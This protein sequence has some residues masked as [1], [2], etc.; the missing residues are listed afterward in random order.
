[1]Q[2]I[3]IFW[4]RQLFC[5][6][7]AHLKIP[8]NRFHILY[9]NV[10]AMLTGPALNSW[11]ALFPVIRL[12]PA[13]SNAWALKFS[14]TEWQRLSVINYIYNK[15]SQPTVS[16]KCASPSN[17]IIFCAIWLFVFL[18]PHILTQACGHLS[19]VALPRESLASFYFISILAS[20]LTFLYFVLPYCF[21]WFCFSVWV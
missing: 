17:D 19:I 18:C 13:L 10:C 2:H 11:Q 20:V 15:L 16:L 12:T 9:V 21:C 14:A 5:S 6:H 3:C 1:M 4:Y 7:F 8:L